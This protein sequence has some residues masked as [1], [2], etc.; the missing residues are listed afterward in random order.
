MSLIITNGDS[1][2]HRLRASGFSAEIL[3]W[4]DILHDGPVPKDL[5]L[6]ELSK[7]RALFIAEINLGDFSEI[8]QSFQHRDAI[9]QNLDKFEEVILCFEH[10][11][12]DQLQLLQLLDWLYHHPS[13][14]QKR[15]LICEEEFLGEMS[16]ERL[17]EL[18]ANRS[19]ITD[20]Q[21]E[22][23][24]L[25]WQAFRSDNPAELNELIIQPHPELPFLN[26]A[27]IRL[28]E[29][30]PS[31]QNGLARNENQICTLI[32][33]GVTQPVELFQKVQVM[34]EAKY[35]GD[36]SFWRYIQNLANTENPLIATQN[37][38]PFCFPQEPFP[39]KAFNL[40]ELQLTELGEDVLAG[41]E[42]RVTV[43]GIDKWIGGVHLTTKNDWRWDKQKT[44][45]KRRQ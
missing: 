38:T 22:T 26:N 20:I 15:T 19:K 5:T 13:P 41:K 16:V 37:N 28:I 40:Q 1:A 10:D 29:E 43:C 39:D 18:Y 25:G 45:M 21:L 6:S 33:N 23:A 14:N 36:W 35:L 9:V 17:K 44:A 8:R 3:P 31:S 32:S 30:Y 42:D 24:K 12:Y 4:R 11:L 7:V 34:E 27:L 2:V